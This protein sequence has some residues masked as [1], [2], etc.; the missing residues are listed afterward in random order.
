MKRLLSTTISGTLEF[1]FEDNGYEVVGSTA[2]LYIWVKVG[3]DLA[4]TEQLLGSRIVVAPGRTFGPGGEGFIRLALVPT[5]Q[6]CEL[7]EQEIR[8]C[9]TNN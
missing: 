6:E 2:G 9:L 1:L 7:A 3:N 4:I 5:L 8:E